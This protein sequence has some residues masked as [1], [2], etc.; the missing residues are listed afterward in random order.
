[1]LALRLRWRKMHRR[2]TAIRLPP[3]VHRETLLRTDHPERALSSERQDRSIRIAT[4]LLCRS[5]A[6]TV[7]SLTGGLKA[8]IIGLPLAWNAGDIGANQSAIIA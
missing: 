3:L 4:E 1:L 5:R 6:V 7:I 8:S 2:P